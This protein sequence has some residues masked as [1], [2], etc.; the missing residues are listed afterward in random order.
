MKTYYKN[1]LKRAYMIL[2]GEIG[3]REDY[4]MIMLKENEI[5]G[6][7]NMDVH[8]VDN[9]SQYYYDISGKT[10]FKTLHEKIN[11]TLDDMQRL[12][13]DLLHAIQ[14]LKKYMLDGKCIL[15][16]PEYIF[17]E[18]ERYYFCYYPSCS[19]DIRK[20]FHRLTEFFVREVNYK[21]EEGVHFAYTL[22]KATME[23]N[24]SIEEIMKQFVSEEKEEIEEIP[25]VPYTERIESM[26]L[27]ESMIE[28]RDSMWDSVRKFLERSKKRKWGYG[29]EDL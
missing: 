17:C 6:I 26:A 14:I 27:E 16:E 13:N 4:Q 19:F 7:L 9:L 24:Y 10:S 20:E 21:D 22:H 15:L 12:V 3:D 23:E 5:P 11:L 2:E 28:E 1:D 29:S 18:K 8:Y 25:I